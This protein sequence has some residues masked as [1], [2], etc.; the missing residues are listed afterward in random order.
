MITCGTTAMQPWQKRQR[1]HHAP[2]TFPMIIQCDP[3]NFPSHPQHPF[4]IGFLWYLRFWSSM[5]QACP[6]LFQASFC[7]QWHV[8]C[9]R[10]DA[11]RTP[12]LQK[13]CKNAIN[14][15]YKVHNASPELSCN[16]STHA[17]KSGIIY[18]SIKVSRRGTPSSHPEYT[19]NEKTSMRSIKVSRRG[20]PSPHPEFTGNEKIIEIIHLATFTAY[21]ADRSLLNIRTSKWYKTY[22]DMDTGGL[23]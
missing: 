11:K 12:E 7:W 20:T 6:R 14:A 22:T 8:N 21:P 10:D 13:Q 18:G 19:G 4:A 23:I 17:L 5:P 9:I 16:F 2:T 3:I 1:H 15:E